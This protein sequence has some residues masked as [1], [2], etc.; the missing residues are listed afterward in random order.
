M[1]VREFLKPVPNME[2]QFAMYHWC[3]EQRY[4]P[5]FTISGELLERISEDE[6]AK[7]V[8]RAWVSPWVA[9]VELALKIDARRRLSILALVDPPRAVEMLREVLQEKYGVCLVDHELPNCKEEE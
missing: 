5:A 2:N 7:M 1:S 4:Y 3:D 8:R 6:L 9:Q